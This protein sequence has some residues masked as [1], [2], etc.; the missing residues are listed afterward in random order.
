[1]TEEWKKLYDTAKA[2]VNPHEITSQMS[3]G[4]V[5]AAVLT[6][7]GNI[8][9]GVCIDT[10]CSL[11]MCAERNA[12]STMITAGE[13]SVTK[14]VAVAT[15]GR[16]LPPCGACR[17]FMMQLVGK[18]KIEILVDGDT[19]V[20]L[21][22]LVAYPYYEKTAGKLVIPDIT[23]AQQIKEYRR[24]FLDVDS[25]LDGCGALKR[26][27]DPG[28]WLAE[29]EK[30][31]KPETVPEGKV[32]ATQFLYVRENDNKLLGMI[33]VRHTLNDYLKEFAGHIGYS[34]RPSE[35]RKGYAKEML[36]AVLPF[37]KG[38][39]LEKVMIT[40]DVDNEGSRKTIIANGGVF[41]STAY[42]P[43]RNKTLERYWITL[44]N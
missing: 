5:A 39:G 15:D 7:D 23:Y 8:Y 36:K 34:V 29:I 42:E 26:L 27:G 19:A 18:E 2:A 16:I 10:A 41:H 28:E 4:G 37:C 3:S 17:E 11:G 38:L 6:E 12:L 31:T 21:K 43:D 24:E 30:Y 13:F 33:Q 32:Q 20:L 1:M 40:C 35:R 25:S 44:N 9:T 22:D 14:V